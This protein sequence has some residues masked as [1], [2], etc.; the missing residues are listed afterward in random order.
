MRISDEEIWANRRSLVK[1][2]FDDDRFDVNNLGDSLITICNDTTNS[3]RD[4]FIKCPALI[5]YCEQGFIRFGSEDDILL[6]GES[7]SNHL[8]AE[9][10]SYYV[11][12]VFVEP[13]KSLFEPFTTL[14][15]TEVKSIDYK[16]CIVLAGFCHNRINYHIA[17]YYSNND[18]L[19]SPY[20]IA[21]RK[22]K[23]ENLPEKYGDDIQEILNK[24]DFNWNDENSGYFYTCA[25]SD[26]LI[27]KLKQFT[28]KINEIDK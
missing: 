23:G 27:E 26:E 3:W 24:Y 20:E 16:A 17:I 25:K 19:S 12:K 14:Y 9:M 5:R 6:Y 2:V 15:Y 13:Q 1:Q 21:F 4:Y 18:K 28:E 7:Q 10:Y 8:H 11:W 22:S